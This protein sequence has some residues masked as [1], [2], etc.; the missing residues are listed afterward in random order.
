MCI[1]ALRSNKVTSKGD[2]RN[3]KEESNTEITEDNNIKEKKMNIKKQA[4]INNW[5]LMRK[6]KVRK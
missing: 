6:S 2:E 5:S 4:V 3:E 1:K